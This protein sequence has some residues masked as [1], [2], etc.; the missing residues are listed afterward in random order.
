MHM[1]KLKVAS[2]AAAELQKLR[3]YENED[4][5]LNHRRSTMPGPKPR[6][7]RLPRG[8]QPPRDMAETPVSASPLLGAKRS[9]PPDPLKPPVAPPPAP[10]C[11]PTRLRPPE[12]RHNTNTHTG[13]ATPTHA[14]GGTPPPPP[15]VRSSRERR[16]PP[17]PPLATGPPWRSS[18]ATATPGHADLRR[19]ALP[20]RRSPPRTALL[21]A[22]K[23]RP[24][25]AAGRGGGEG[26]GGRS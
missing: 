8:A 17:P 9:L 11:R 3:A 26:Q 25:A 20:P 19:N 24:A 15:H 14:R 2:P 5:D 6:L 18:P 22:G 16:L 23:G 4:V 1:R 12:Q 10:T 7:L 21:A 13:H